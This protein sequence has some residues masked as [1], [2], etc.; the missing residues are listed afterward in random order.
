M[1]HSSI[2]SVKSLSIVFAWSVVGAV[3]GLAPPAGAA[4]VT[5][6][7]NANGA[8]EVSVNGVPNQGDPDGTAIGTVFLDSGTTGNTGTAIISVVVSNI[9]FPFSGFH[10]HQ[11]PVTTTGPIVLNFGNPESFSVGNT[12][13]AT[14]T[15]LSSATINSAI[16]DPSGFYFNMHNTPFPGGAVRDQLGILAPSTVPEPSSL[17]L[18][19]CGLVGIVVARRRRR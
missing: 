12:V 15:N 14:I 1:S 2:L 6:S 16:A 3:L 19:S 10:I 11:A 9:D 7:I 13:N 18:L 8:K 5:F 4:S 17:V